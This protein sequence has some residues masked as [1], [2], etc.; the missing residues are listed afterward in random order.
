MMTAWDDLMSGEGVVLADGGMG[1]TLFSLGLDRG[2]APEMWNLEHPDRIA[3]IHRGYIDAGA[4][5]I[6]TNSFG[7]NRAR[8]GRHKLAERTREINR[9]AAK[10][11]R[12]EADAAEEPILVGGSLGPTG[13]L[14]EPLGDLSP[15]E[16]ET[17]FTEQA[18]GLIDGGVDV[19]WIET[20][21]D[22]QE[23]HAA[24]RGCIQAGT[25]LPLVATMT[26]DTHGH[27]S[28]GVSPEDAVANLADF[29]LSA[30]GANCGNG[31]EEIEVVIAKMHAA[32]PSKILVAK[33]N[34]GMPRLH[35]GKTTY[36]ASPEIMAEH[37]LRV[38][39]LGA[40]IIGACCG[41]TADHIRAMRKAI[42]S[43]AG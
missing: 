21:S 18:S 25:D 3:K 20:M 37:A 40:R 39:A 10:I 9:A 31:P 38:S 15:T 19:L 36:D 1:T 43:H 42:L 26:F 22:L 7:G 5:I 2:T 34:A 32:A 41:S 14:M 24:L 16:A 4:Q 13:R 29:N 23:V 12:G 6:L 28:M 30:I 17:I 27:T 33:S 8:L 11:A 35:E